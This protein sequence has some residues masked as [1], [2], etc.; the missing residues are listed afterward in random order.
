MAWLE[1][2][3]DEETITAR[4][5]ELGLQISEAYDDGEPL[6]VIC[7]LKGSFLFMADLVRAID[8]DVHCE[9]LGVASYEGRQ[10]SGAV[11]ITKDLT[12]PIEGQHCLIVEDI[13]DTGL[14]LSFLLET[15][16]LRDP[17]SLSVVALLDK[18]SRRVVPSSA[19]YVG[20]EI[21]DAFVVGYG[22][23]LDQRYRNLPYVAVYHPEDPPD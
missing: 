16:R 7:V 13:V 4:V 17:A 20:F 10:S 8:L 5:R 1:T 21:P 19:D 22:L 18:P 14:T 3:I 6:L 11:Q 9:F 15:L 12:A 23:D 2:L